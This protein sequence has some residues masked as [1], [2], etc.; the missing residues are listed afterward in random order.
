LKKLLVRESSPLRM[1]AQK[2]VNDNGLLTTATAIGVAPHTLRNFL[3]GGKVQN[4]TLA[5][6]REQLG[7]DKL[8]TPLIT[9][10]TRPAK[11][12]AAGQRES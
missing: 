10:K 12:K 8:P 11:K 3:L 7:G 6:L 4:G 2:V 5:L 9:V 1:R